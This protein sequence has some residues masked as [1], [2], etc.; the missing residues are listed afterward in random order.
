MADAFRGLKIRLGADARP[1]NSAINSVK[2][3]AQATQKQLNAM[4]KALKFDPANVSALSQRVDLVGNKAILAA[5]AIRDIRTTMNQASAGT[6]N[7][8]ASTDNVYAAVQ[9]AR[10][11]YR[12]V[13]GQLQKMHD[14]VRRIIME[15]MQLANPALDVKKAFEL[16]DEKVKDMARSFGKTDAEAQKLTNEM[17]EYLALANKRGLGQVFN[18][19]GDAD[20]LIKKYETLKGQTKALAGALSQLKYAE[21]L[22]AAKTQ[23]IAWESELRQASSEAARF[24]SELHTMAAGDPFGDMARQ[25]Q[26]IDTAI[27]EASASARKM[28]TLFKMTPGSIENAKAKLLAEAAVQESL[29]DKIKAQEAILSGMDSKVKDIANS[30]RNVYKW[31]SQ[32][33]RV[34]AENDSEL[35]KAKV[36]LEGIADKMREAAANSGKGSQEVKELANEYKWVNQEVKQ[37]TSRAEA[38]D[39][40][41]ETANGARKYR[42]VSEDLRVARAEMTATTAKASALR[43]AL[44]FSKTIRTMGYG[45]YSTI[46]PAIMIAGRY[47]LQSA[48]DIDSAYRDMRKTVNGTEAQ[49]EGLLDDA[50]KFSTTH[51]TTAEQMLEIESIGGQLGIA[52]DKL[53]AFGET[54]ANLDIATNIDAETVS[55]QL[56]K[57]ATVLGLNES[58]YDNFGDALVRLGNN[59]P[60]M[61]SDIMTLATRFMGMGKVVGMSADQILGWSAAASATGQ[62]SEAAGSSMQRFISNMETAV[63]SGGDKL[64]KWASIARMSGDE[65][66]AAFREDA[67]GAMY[68]FIEGLGEMQKNGESVNQALMDLGIN[69]VRDKQLLEGLAV[70]M[71]NAGDGT[72]VLAKSLGMAKDAYEGVATRF[73]DGTIEEAGDA[74]REAGKKAEGFSG[75]VQQMINTAQLLSQELAKGALPYVKMLKEMFQQATDAL[76]AMPDGAKSAIVGLLGITAALGP[77]AVGFGAVGAAVDNVIELWD[78][79]LGA[80]TMK[81]A[82][83]AMAGV[84][85]A[86]GLL[87]ETFP[88]AA[89]AAEFLGK[90]LTAIGPSALKA[91]PVLAALAAAAVMLGMTFMELRE[92]QEAYTKATK[93]MSDAVK[94]VSAAAHDNKSAVEAVSKENWDATGSINALIKSHGE[95]VDSMNDRSNAAKTEIENL[96]RAESAI[97]KYLGKTGLTVQQQSELRAAIELLNSEYGTQY[98]VVD[99]ANGIVA[100]ERGVLL[101][102]KDAIL[103]YIEAKK[104]Q[105]KADQLAASAVEA[106]NAL[107]DSVATLA[108]AKKEYNDYIRDYGD[109]MGKDAVD[110]FGNDIDARATELKTAVDT[111][112]AI[113]ASDQE[114]VD[115][116]NDELEMVAE[117][118]KHVSQTLADVAAR[119]TTL[120]KLFTGDKTGFEAFRSELTQTGLSVEDFKNISA[121]QWGEIVTQWNNGEVSLA[122]IL[123]G[124]GYNLTSLTDQMR[125]SFESL[126]L[127]FDDFVAQLGG[128]AEELAAKLQSAGGAA[129]VFANVTEADIATA[130]E[131]SGGSVDTFIAKLQQIGQ[132]N[133]KASVEAEGGEEAAAEMG[134]V[135]DAA[136]EA[137]GAT[138]TAYAE[139]EGAEETQEQFENVQETVDET[140]GD[141]AAVS[142]HV[143]DYATSVIDSIRD[144]LRSLDGDSATVTVYK[145]G[146]DAAG[147]FYRLHANG[148]FG[149]ITNGPISLGR[150]KFG[151]EHIAGEAGR[152][153]I[154]RHAD[155]TTSI[156]PIEN[157][158]YLKPYAREIAGMIGGAGTTNY[159][160]T[161]DYKAG[162]DAN[163]IVRDLNRAVRAQNLMGG[164]R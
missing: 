52:A 44:D 85:T 15:E 128:N 66:A 19:T 77:M 61:E 95:L 3:A 31:V 16:A 101:T 157:R 80:R 29:N 26:R 35:V 12:G 37:L 118:G 152:E 32:L 84:R 4:N 103:E 100:D 158:R 105:I 62:K 14:S 121:T 39:N 119:N 123:S 20:K 53:G 17:K 34:W 78:K 102:T 106:N 136:A 113:V 134:E 58:Q 40:E 145:Q 75:Q 129:E 151:I 104:Q 147:G 127:N 142:V 115:T 109:Q 86:G 114:A 69:N 54:V 70:Q 99:A 150:D 64:E 162:D 60:V 140:D 90:K 154:K 8:A 1:L 46:T 161:L 149:F 23:L 112:S 11:E 89:K 68:S 156:V 30:T 122:S 120:Q 83:S 110:E 24:R 10:S 132:Q 160:I 163:K 56:G 111:A 87:A 49:F 125:S 71:Q 28:D 63:V 88:G 135:V 148:G 55:E 139:E 98:Q 47:A 108:K 38:L 48:R 33:E 72:S 96:G 164:R 57:M 141:S 41:L 126:G 18:T 97:D 13:N 138:A 73:D 43:R 116:I 21:G 93:G 22:T 50:L 59:M 5:R 36:R 144:N 67:S 124:M 42:Q 130:L 143:N 74:A 27:D 2:S 92:K 107:D 79:A 137:D 91:A 159:Y 6:K 7:L 45:L 9:K 65:F 76:T 81:A 25:I 94:N 153:W 82:E 146:G 117:E 131:A 51:F 133:V 155:G